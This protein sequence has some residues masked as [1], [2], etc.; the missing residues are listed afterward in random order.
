MA[1]TKQKWLCEIVNENIDSLKKEKCLILFGVVLTILD[2]LLLNLFFDRYTLIISFVFLSMIIFFWVWK[3]KEYLRVEDE[4]GVIPI[5]FYLIPITHL[6][7]FTI[8]GIA[9]I[10]V[11]YLP[12]IILGIILSVIF[13][14]AVRLYYL[15]DEFLSKRKLNK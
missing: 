3:N 11:E 10:S 6:L 14:L 13:S 8:V 5:S 12:F 4:W 1:K 2:I 7:I 15:I 9:Y